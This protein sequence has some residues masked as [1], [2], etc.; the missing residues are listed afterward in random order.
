MLICCRFCA[1]G[2][3]EARH[4]LAP[5][6]PLVDSATFADDGAEVL[7]SQGR[8]RLRY[9][10][11]EDIPGFLQASGL[12]QL[13]ADGPQQVPDPR[14]EQDDRELGCLPQSG[15]LPGPFQQ[16]PDECPAQTAVA[17]SA[18]AELR[19]HLFGLARRPPEL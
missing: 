3:E 6:L 4:V 14:Q 16:E 15:K 12:R 9:A 5:R 11:E 10:D 19:D 7:A 18:A 8:P 1:V 17:T 13:F 2:E